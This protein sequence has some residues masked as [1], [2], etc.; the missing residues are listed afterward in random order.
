MANLI[1]AVNTRGHT[2][3]FDTEGHA[4]RGAQAAWVDPAD[5]ATARLLGDGTLRQI[6]PPGEPAGDLPNADPEPLPDEA[7]PT[8]KARTRAAK[9]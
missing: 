8:P 5:R 3:A 2:V 4:L 7:E 9:N 6:Q 1:Y